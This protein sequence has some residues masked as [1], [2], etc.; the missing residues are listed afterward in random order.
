[1]TDIIEKADKEISETI[2]LIEKTE[3]SLKSAP[4]GTLNTDTSKDRV[5]YYNRLPGSAQKRIYLSKDKLALAAALAQKDYDK[6]VLKYLNKKRAALERLCAEYPKQGLDSVYEGLS[7]Q[8]QKL[9]KPVAL[10]D[11]QLEK[12]WMEAEYQGKRFSEQDT[13]CFYTDNQERVRSKSE[14]IIANHL[15]HAGILYKYECPLKIGG[16]CLYPDF[17][18]LDIKRRRQVYLEHFGMMDDPGYAADFLWKM[19]FYPRNGIIPG[20]NLIVTF[21]DSQH[22]LDTRVLKIQLEH[23]LG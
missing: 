9:V 3:S 19:N 16:R 14:V 2:L 23:M 13:G 22:P 20:E 7:V 8:R 10:T 18:I 11:R 6:K 4:P 15:F 21:E 12:A 17:T 1:M 5:E